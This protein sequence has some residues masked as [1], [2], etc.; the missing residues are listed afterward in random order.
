MLG[1]FTIFSIFVSMATFIIWANTG[2]NDRQLFYI[3]LQCFIISIILLKLQFIQEQ[4]KANKE[5]ISELKKALSA[6]NQSTED[7]INETP[8]TK[9]SQEDFTDKKTGD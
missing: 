2:F 3:F 6:H 8:E 4:V 1:L 7:Q 9:F 5:E